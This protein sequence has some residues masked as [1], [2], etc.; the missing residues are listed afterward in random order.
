M[1][2]R[3]PA[4]PRGLDEDAQILA[5]GFLPH[6]FAERLRTQ[7][8]VGVFA[9]ALGRGQPVGIGSAHRRLHRNA[10]T[11]NLPEPTVAK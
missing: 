9:A 7:G 1:V 11:T 5:R 2:H 3:L 10:S 8:G 4:A 6:E